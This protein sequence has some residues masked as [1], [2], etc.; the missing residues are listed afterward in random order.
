M[1]LSRATASDSKPLMMPGNVRAIQVVSLVDDLGELGTGVRISELAKKTG[2]DSQVLISVLSA[3]EMLGLIENENGNL[4]LSEEGLKL[5]EVQMAKVSA[6]L[7]EKVAP[8][9]P[10]RTAID[11]ASKGGRTT[12]GE[13]AKT[14]G[15]RHRM[16]LQT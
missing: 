11:L 16:A 4:F 12:A 5:K 10:F 6:I 8:I 13:I 7:K 1:T 3:G 2:I 9:E 14:K 15:S